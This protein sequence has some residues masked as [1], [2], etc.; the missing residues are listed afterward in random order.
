MLL[1]NTELRVDRLMRALET[2]MF[3]GEEVHR[4][5]QELRAIIGKLE[6]CLDGH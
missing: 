2:G 4:R 6:D 1:V 5:I 3:T